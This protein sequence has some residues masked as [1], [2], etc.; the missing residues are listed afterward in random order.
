VLRLLINFSIQSIKL[1]HS[2]IRFNTAPNLHFIF[3]NLIYLGLQK[4]KGRLIE[5]SRVLL[6]GTTSSISFHEEFIMMDFRFVTAKYVYL[7]GR[8]HTY[9]HTHTHTHTHTHSTYTHISSL[10][11]YRPIRMSRRVYLLL[12]I[13]RDFGVTFCCLYWQEIIKIVPHIGRVDNCEVRNKR[14]QS[15]SK[16]S[17]LIHS[18]K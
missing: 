3:L 8:I 14:K 11:M 5:A 17:M 12:F 15:R 1:A 18:F 2:F 7:L 6:G 10:C 9:I 13:D 16:V 4:L